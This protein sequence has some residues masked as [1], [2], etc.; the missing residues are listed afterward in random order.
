MNSKFLA[1][2]A[3]SF[4]ALTITPVIHAQ[5]LPATPAIPASIPGAIPDGATLPNALGNP[6]SPVVGSPSNPAGSGTDTLPNT[7]G[8]PG[9]PVRGSNN[10]PASSSNGTSAGQPVAQSGSYLQISLPNNHGLPGGSGPQSLLNTVINNVLN[11]LALIAIGALIFA[12]VQLVLAQG[13]A[14]AIGSAKGN[15]INIIIGFA[16]VMLAWSGVNIVLKFIG[17]GN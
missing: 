9:S 5:T 15:I 14:D 11:F 3:F 17:F 12:G 2:L 7:S 16:I 6:G 4:L 8:N 1:T 13:K 10:L